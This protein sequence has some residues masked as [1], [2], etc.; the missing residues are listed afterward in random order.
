MIRELPFYS[1]ATVVQLPTGGSVN[2][3][4]NEIMLWAC[5]TPKGRRDLPSGA[6][7]FPVIFHSGNNHN[8][9]IQDTQ[10]LS[11]AHLDRSI[12]TQFGSIR[13]SGQQLPLLPFNLWL[14]CNVPHTR[15]I[16]N[17]RDAVCLELDQGIVV[18]PHSATQRPRLPILGMRGLINN[19]LVVSIDCNRCRLSIR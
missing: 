12:Y 9:S 18:Y 8:L 2:I 11:W 3:G 4:A 6:K 13:A 15:K 5:L 7:H 19:K 17:S 16:Q 1:A 14:L 10:L